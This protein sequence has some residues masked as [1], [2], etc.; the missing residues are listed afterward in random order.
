MIID[1]K[2]K[3]ELTHILQRDLLEL[4]ARR[5]GKGRKWYDYTVS[6]GKSS[7]NPESD[8]DDEVEEVKKDKQPDTSHITKKTP[9]QVNPKNAKHFRDLYN[10]ITRDYEKY[11]NLAT[12]NELDEDQTLVYV[13]RY[14]GSHA[15][16]TLSTTTEKILG[17]FS[18]VLHHIDSSIHFTG[19]HAYELM[20]DVQ[21]DLLVLFDNMRKI[22]P[23]DMLEDKFI[24]SWIQHVRR[25]SK[26]KD[27]STDTNQKQ[28]WDQ[29]KQA[30]A[31]NLIK[32]DWDWHTFAYAIRSRFQIFCAVNQSTGTY[33]YISHYPMKPQGKGKNQ[34]ISK[35]FWQKL[36]FIHVDQDSEKTVAFDYILPGQTRQLRSAWPQIP[37]ERHW[38]EIN[39][40][41]IADWPIKAHSQP[42]EF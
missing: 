1:K 15:E 37:R 42:V 36:I 39:L 20:F 14:H 29:T 27:F 23:K 13:A 41:E 32:S 25:I 38:F 8:E 24:D 12:I 30:Y 35:T 2:T 16:E 19:G 10:E 9:K 5:E 21:R 3:E 17:R 33:D 18:M 40:N 22:L 31:N 4:K 6:G 34:D 11:C 28:V 26:N 7:N